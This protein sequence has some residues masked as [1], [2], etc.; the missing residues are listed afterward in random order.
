MEFALKFAKNEEKIQIV[1]FIS[2]WYINQ[3]QI[4]AR[5]LG[6]VFQL[7]YKVPHSKVG[8][9]RYIERRGAYLGLIDERVLVQLTENIEYGHQ[10]K[11]LRAEKVQEERGYFREIAELMRKPETK[12]GNTK[13]MHAALHLEK[14]IDEGAPKS[15]I[16]R[17]ITPNETP[18]K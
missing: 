10:F 2:F 14:L 17:A 7:V 11:P 5:T 12:I 1:K 4:N 16:A 3:N 8:F 13:F 15:E 6:E 9:T 18:L